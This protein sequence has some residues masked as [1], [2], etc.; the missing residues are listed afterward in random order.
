MIGA[1]TA[2]LF[3]GGVAASTNSYESIATT[4]VGILGAANVVFSSIPSTYKHLQIRGIAR[5]DEVATANVVSYRFNGDTA[6]NYSA[7][8]IYGDGSAA[9]G[10]GVANSSSMNGVQLPAATASASI[11]NAVIIDIL[12]YANTSKYKTL[13][14]L[15]GSDRN[16]SG[17]LRF[18][19]GN[20]RDTTAV[21]SVTITP[22]GGNF[23]QY[24]SFALYGIKG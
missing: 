15:G 5:S 17:E 20:W 1:I 2:G 11:F 22:A 23:V 13:R 18:T 19:S 8:F 12:D 10:Y 14:S 21:S 24:S 9:G 16:G 7:H 4:T 3:S 6:A